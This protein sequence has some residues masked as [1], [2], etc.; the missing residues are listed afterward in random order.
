MECKTNWLNRTSA[1]DHPTPVTNINLDGSDR[2]IKNDFMTN[3]TIKDILKKK[4][5]RIVQVK[6]ILFGF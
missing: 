2:N 1:S 6:K 3:S 5:K 4:K